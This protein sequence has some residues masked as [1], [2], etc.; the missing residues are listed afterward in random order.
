MYARSFKRYCGLP[1]AWR[2]TL[3]HHDSFTHK[4]SYKYFARQYQWLT[5]Y[6]SD[7]WSTTNSLP[8]IHDTLWFYAQM[9]CLIALYYVLCKYTS[10]LYKNY[11]SS[12]HVCLIRGEPWRGQKILP[13]YLGRLY[14]NHQT[15]R[16]IS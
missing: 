13:Q 8:R 14:W 6:R 7:N 1:A 3:Q 4:V 9:P 11:Q 12:W 10:S 2:V 15:S 16:Y 5:H